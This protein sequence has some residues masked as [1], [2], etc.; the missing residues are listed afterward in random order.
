MQNN[1]LHYRYFKEKVNLYDPVSLVL[2]VLF[3]FTA[4]FVVPAGAVG[5]EQKYQ[6]K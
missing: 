2:T 5:K 3:L 6:A 4:L 1:S